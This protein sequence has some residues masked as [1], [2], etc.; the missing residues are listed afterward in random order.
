MQIRLG[1]HK[2][3]LIY[4]APIIYT[5]DDFLTDEECQHFINVAKPNLKRSGV[6][7][8]DQ[9]NKRKDKYD[10]KHRDSSQHWIKPGS[11]D[12]VDAVHERVSNAVQMPKENS[13][14]FQVMHYA[15]G[16][17]FRAHMDAF[18]N[19]SPSYKDYL[20]NG[21]QRILTAMVY[22]NDNVVGGETEFTK[23]RHYVKPKKGMLLVWH[24][25]F[26]G[27]DK[28]TPMSMH[29][30]RTVKAGE[31]WAFSLWYRQRPRKD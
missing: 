17:T 13:E 14:K 12:I 7:G 10:F 24:N 5:V 2:V 29:S 9:E 27:T 30:G 31:K 18:D 4:H 6:T 20:K 15:V 23:I 21:G 8:Y 26:K 22:L 16:Q 11:D 28:R 3:H 1:N 25:C 19:K